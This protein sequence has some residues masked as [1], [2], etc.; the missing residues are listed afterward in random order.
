MSIKEL[1]RVKLVQD[2]LDGMMK[3]GLAARQMDVTPRHFRRIL[4]RYR[5]E[6]AAGLASKS[7]NR[8]SNHRLPE[9]LGGKAIAIVRQ[10]YP[11]FGPTFAAEKL[12]EQ[13]G[14]NLSKE[15][16]HKSGS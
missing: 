16:L 5:A 10:D 4:E 12:R 14:V 3:P 9:G 1:N 2:V 7:R 11:D 6:G 8:P 15:P 13:H